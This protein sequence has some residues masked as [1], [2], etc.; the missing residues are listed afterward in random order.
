VKIVV[1]GAGGMLGRELV[2]ILS[3][4]HQ[5]IGL[6]HAELDILDLE[7]TK[8]TIYKIKP[9]L[10]IHAAAYT[11][12]DGCER[13]PDKAYSVNT[14]GTQ[15]VALACQKA[16]AILLYT[17]TDFVFNGTKGKPY[18]EWDKPEPINV[19]GK[20]KYA[21]ERVVAHLLNQYYIVRT[22]WLYGEHGRN[23]PATIL[24]KAKEEKNLEVVSDQVGSPTFTYDV[25]KGIEKLIETGS[26]GIYHMVNTGECSWYEFARKILDLAGYRDWEVKPITSEQLGRPAKRPSYSVL[27]NFSLER[28]AGI[29]MRSWEEA[30]AEFMQRISF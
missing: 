12:V 25:V 27:R 11:D 28:V 29:A 17:S 8:K 14:I 30:I 23:F 1:T 3:E 4:R 15:N 20:S 16:E 6:S 22:A 10:V 9:E 21:G 18:L 19:Y 13:N 7:G 24:A 26:F 2:K 5:V